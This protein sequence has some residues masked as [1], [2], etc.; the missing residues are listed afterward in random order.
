MTSLSSKSKMNLVLSTAT[1]SSHLGPRKLILKTLPQK[2]LNLKTKQQSMPPLLTTDKTLKISA[3][4]PKLKYWIESKKLRAS[5]WKQKKMRRWL[6]WSSFWK[7]ICLIM[8]NIALKK[9]GKTSDLWTIFLFPGLR[10]EFRK[11]SAKNLDRFLLN[12]EESNFWS[13]SKRS[14]CYFYVGRREFGRRKW[15]TIA[16]RR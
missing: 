14:K 2:I 5:R 13:I 12:A 9:H 10:R 4:I 6:W 3:G 7:D 15:V 1:L 8:N 11:L 16:E